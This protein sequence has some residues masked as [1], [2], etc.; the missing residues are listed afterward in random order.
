L[1]DLPPAL[2]APRRANRA[3]HCKTPS[4]TLSHPRIDS[5]ATGAHRE[6]RYQARGK[7]LPGRGSHP[8]D[9][10]PLP[11]RTKTWPRLLIDRL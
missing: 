7:R 5:P 1:Q 3:L 8:L 10:A 2:H 6:A 9:Y 11:G 4:L